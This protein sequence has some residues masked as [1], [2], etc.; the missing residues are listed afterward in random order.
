MEGKV[1]KMVVVFLCLVRSGARDLKSSIGAQITWRKVFGG[2]RIWTCTKIA[3]D[4]YVREHLDIRK[5][6]MRAKHNA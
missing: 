4:K 5:C 1:A 2:S 3:L 6:S